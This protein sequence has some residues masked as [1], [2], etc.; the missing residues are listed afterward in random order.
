MGGRQSTALG[1]RPPDCAISGQ[2]F[3]AEPRCLDVLS[4][5][6]Q[7]VRRSARLVVVV[8]VFVVFVVVAMVVVM[9]VVVVVSAH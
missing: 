1:D 8:V 3:R 7:L 6:L 2:S 5:D 9:M 4:G